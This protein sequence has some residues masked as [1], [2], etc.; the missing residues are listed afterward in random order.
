MEEKARVR[1]AMLEA[2]RSLSPAQRTLEEELVAAAVQASP[3]WAAAQVVALYRSKAPEFS[4]VGLT[5][6][7]WRAGKA[8]A[9]PCVH[10]SGLVLRLASAWDQFVPGP[11]G[12]LEPARSSPPVAPDQLGLC[13]V[14]GVAWDRTGGRLGRGGGYYDR[15]IPGLDCPV[16]GIGFDAQLVPAVPREAHDA[17]VDKV[18]TMASLG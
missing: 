5:L 15:L 12:L 2:L 10:G 16:W 17:T 8:T 3:E 1:A 9:F 7:A 6:A 13:L 11:L 4:T 18:W 14:P